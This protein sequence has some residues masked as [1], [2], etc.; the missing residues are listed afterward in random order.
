[1]KKRIVFIDD[2]DTFEIPLFRKALELRF[3]IVTGVELEPVR[4]QIAGTD[5]KPELFVLDLYFPLGKPDKAAL[6]DIRSSKLEIMGTRRAGAPNRACP[7]NPRCRR[8]WRAGHRCPLPGG[9]GAYTNS[10]AIYG[11]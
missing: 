4:T 1:M 7:H 10:P 6:A 11:S 2:D 3:D 9:K 5:W 8:L